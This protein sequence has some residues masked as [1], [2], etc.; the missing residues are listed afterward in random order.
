MFLLYTD[1]VDPDSQQFRSFITNYVT[2]EAKDPKTIPYP[3]LYKI[4]KEGIREYIRQKKGPP[5]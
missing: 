4:I 5:K 3:E 1:N 2:K